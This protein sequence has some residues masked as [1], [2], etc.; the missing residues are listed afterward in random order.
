MSPVETV[1]YAID[2]EVD[3][4][5]AMTSLRFDGPDGLFLLAIIAPPP[6]RDG[7]LGHAHS[8]RDGTTMFHR[9]GRVRVVARR[10]AGATIERLADRALAPPVAR[11]LDGW[12][13]R[14]ELAAR[15]V[16]EADEAYV[17]RLASDL[18]LDT[19]RAVL[20]EPALERRV[21]LVVAAVALS[22]HEELADA[23][24][25]ARD[26]AGAI[27]DPALRPPLDALVA[28]PSPR[29][30]GE[31][32]DAYAG[33]Q[34]A[35]RIAAARALLDAL[36]CRRDRELD[37]LRAALAPLS[38]RSPGADRSGTGCASRGRATPPPPAP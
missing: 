17:D 12:A 3:F 28:P 15:E 34:L 16:D 35:A 8:L 18:D 20:E 4:L 14:H 37:D 25:E 30:A 10:G 31:P 9:I 29:A 27:D 1:L 36:A 21:E 24:E 19:R 32:L 13:R 6:S 23:V 11:D 33:R 38:W 7:V 5:G 2:P 22:G 26:A